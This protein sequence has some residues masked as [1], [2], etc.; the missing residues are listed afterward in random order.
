MQAINYFHEGINNDFDVSK[1]R[2]TEWVHPSQNARVINKEGQG[3]IITDVNGNNY[4]EVNQ[5]GFKLPA[6]FLVLGK[7]ESDG[8]LYLILHNPTTGEGEIGCYPSPR[9]LKTYTYGTGVLID[10]TLTGFD[11]KY[12]PLVNFRTAGNVAIPFRTTQFTFD[13]AKRVDLIVKPTFDGTVNLYLADGLNYNRVINSGFNK[14]GEIIPLIT[15]KATDF[16]NI[17][18]QVPLVNWIP[19]L[20]GGVSVES[21]GKWK[22]GNTFLF[23][24]YV[25][26][27]FNR[28]SFL[29]EI[30][31][32]QV[33][34]GNNN[35]YTQVE[36][37]LGYAINAEENETDKRIVFTLS[38]LDQSYKF[39]EIG[40][41][42]YW[43]D[44]NG[45][46]HKD[47]KLIE[48][49]FEIT[50]PTKQV[51]LT[52]YETVSDI[53]EGEF[54]AG[55]IRELT[56]E[57]HAVVDNY[58]YGANW[59]RNSY[60][61]EYLTEYASRI[62][63]SYDDNATIDKSIGYKN[64]ENARTKVGYFRTEA[65][66]FSI[67]YVFTGGI[68]S[69]AYPIKGADCLTGSPTLFDGGI[70]RFPRHTTSPLFTSPNL[71]IMGIKFDNTAAEAYR[72]GTA[73]IQQWFADNIEGFYIVRGDRYQN[74][75]YQGLMMYGTKSFRKHVSTMSNCAAIVEQ[76]A[77][78]STV[79]GGNSDNPNGASPACLMV[80]VAGST[81]LCYN[82]DDEDFWYFS[83]NLK[84]SSDLV[85]TVYIPT[86]ADTGGTVSDN[87]WADWVG[88]FHKEI[89]YNKLNSDYFGANRDAD[90]DSM[91]PPKFNDEVAHNDSNVDCDVEEDYLIPVYKGFI[92][93]F[94]YKNPLDFTDS[95]EYIRNSL[96]R[97]YY[98]EKKYG[99]FSPDFI[100]DQLSN[101]NKG[102]ILKKIGTVVFQETTNGYYGGSI[103][104][105]IDCSGQASSVYPWWYLTN[106]YS[107][108]Q[109]SPVDIAN[110]KLVEVPKYTLLSNARN[111]FVSEYTDPGFVSDGSFGFE[112]RGTCMFY[113]EQDWTVLKAAKYSGG[114]RSMS[115][116]K[117]I[118]VTLPQHQAS[119]NHSIVNIHDFDPASISGDELLEY[120]DLTNQ[121]YYKISGFL[122]LTNISSQVFYKGD[123]FLQS[124]F[125]KQMAWRGSTYSK[126]NIVTGLENDNR[127]STDDDQPL[128]HF[129]HG[130][131]ME[132]ITEN[133]I[134]TEMRFSAEERSFYPKTDAFTMAVANP[135]TSEKTESLL[136]NAGYNVTLSPKGYFNF[137]KNLPFLVTEFQ[138]RIRP[139]DKYNESSYIDAFRNFKAERYQDYNATEGPI[140]RVVN[141]NNELVSL[142]NEKVNQHYTAERQAKTDTDQGSII[143]GTG[144]ELSPQVRV[145]SNIGLYHKWALV[146]APNAIYYIN[147]NKRAVMRITNGQQ[148]A[149][150]GQ[151]LTIEKKYSSTI[152]QLFE[153]ISRYT[154]KKSDFEDDIYNGTGFSCGYESK[155]KDVLF[156]IKDTNLTNGYR[157]FAFS[158]I[159]DAF[160]FD[161]SFGSPCYASLRNEFYSL[162]WFDENHTQMSKMYLHDDETKILTFYD[163]LVE[164]KLSFIVNG[165]NEENNTS[166]LSKRY[167]SIEMEAD[168]DGMKEIY[169]ET[170]KQVGYH[171]VFSSTDARFWL[172]P[173]Y[174]EG[175]WKLPIVQQTSNDSTGEFYADSSMRGEWLKVTFVYQKNKRIF[176]KNNITN[177]E[178][179]KF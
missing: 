2:N 39:F 177:Y 69:D 59:K 58:Y 115:V 31:P 33:A 101:P 171:D 127:G 3:L 60:H 172:A 144:T 35:D 36:G 96:G 159:L 178:V 53:I 106:V 179:S 140:L 89:E 167:D 160:T 173:E 129:G 14:N 76:Y 23:V 138:S 97:S 74:V 162:R 145:I 148:G 93:V 15:Y 43:G 38:S 109:V 156:T 107:L 104:D 77:E 13:S 110:A 34:K 63:P 84:T 143:M 161:Y 6:G 50:A 135:D 51:I 103:R 130:L 5:I 19:T 75:K 151:D 21:G 176:I 120:F 28:T 24:R 108:T 157:T 113:W 37:V 79:H 71:N 68:E 55:T 44:Q 94:Q 175:K 155:Y 82:V 166:M 163:T 27:N 99:F 85:S 18:S 90:L 70:Y 131:I 111:N 132:F 168:P 40:F 174:M 118:G 80:G 158:E 65:Y 49:R 169:Y 128:I 30:G 67:V 95:K 149:L 26:Y 83:E 112:K 4:D 146:E 133:A 164:M 134:N 117:Y 122:N 170:L 46:V 29:T 7:K 121:V 78:A 32:I 86:G 105:M 119:L 54:L 147:A 56:S 45:V 17:V 152:N 123:C 102:N 11:R 64:A 125:I 142:Q 62:I 165:L 87:L 52:G 73:A 153:T 141:L 61:H 9:Q 139:S 98:V 47:I 124:T 66:P 137:N 91:S 41:V 88:Q 114:N 154:N 25:T 16:P 22:S 150:V 100:F 8:I 10:D 48:E 20:A 1:V 12:K 126:N 42:R 57:S 81:N 116:A 136:T 92:P 72:T